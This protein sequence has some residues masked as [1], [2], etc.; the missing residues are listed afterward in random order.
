MLDWIHHKFLK[1][2]I[3]YVKLDLALH[4]NHNM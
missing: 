1:L 2:N 4:K 3:P